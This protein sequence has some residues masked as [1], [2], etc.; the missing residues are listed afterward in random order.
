MHYNLRQNF[1]FWKGY[2]QKSLHSPRNGHIYIYKTNFNFLFPSFFFC[3]ST[4]FIFIF[5][6]KKLNPNYVNP[7]W[8]SSLKLP[9]L[10][11][12][13]HHRQQSLV[14]KEN[15]L[16]CRRGRKGNINLFDDVCDDL[17]FILGLETSNLYMGKVKIDNSIWWSENIENNWWWVMGSEW[18]PIL[19]GFE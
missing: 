19:M 8:N 1:E 10:N 14:V 4:L 3:G 15:L 11:F 13:N 7:H 12:H 6:K 17:S 2:V 16:S 9:Y 5:S 18:F